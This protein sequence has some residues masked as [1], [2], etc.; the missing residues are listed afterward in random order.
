[1]ISRKCD[2][3]MERMEVVGEVEIRGTVGSRKV[4]RPSSGT[5]SSCCLLFYRCSPRVSL[6]GCGEG[7]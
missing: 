1:M 7:E 6:R 3:K 4:M 2:G 5:C